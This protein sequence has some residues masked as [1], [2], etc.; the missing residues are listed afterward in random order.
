MKRRT[1]MFESNT[2]QLTI[3]AVMAGFFIYAL[4]RLFFEAALPW[5]NL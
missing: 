5:A 1:K 4:T 2:V 3:A